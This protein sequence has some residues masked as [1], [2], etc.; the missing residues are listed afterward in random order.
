MKIK[1]IVLLFLG[2]M[3]GFAQS[4]KKPVGAKKAVA[5]APVKK[6]TPAASNEGIFAE[7]ETA[8]GKIIVQLEYKK[9]GVSYIDVEY[10]NLQY[11]YIKILHQKRA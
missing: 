1:V 4:T 3:S 5:T 7:I 8:K 11:H 2:M 9:T 6:A 10:K